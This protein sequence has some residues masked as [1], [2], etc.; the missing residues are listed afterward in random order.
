VCSSDL[1]GGSIEDD[2]DAGTMSVF[3]EAEEGGCAVVGPPA[4]ALPLVAALLW[5]GRRSRAAAPSQ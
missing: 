2:F 5:L 1:L 4:G 3:P